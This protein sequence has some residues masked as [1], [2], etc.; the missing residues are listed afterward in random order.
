MKGVLFLL[1]LA[2]APAA[3]DT[4]VAAHTIRAQTLLSP[5]DLAMV[6]RDVPGALTDP[7]DADG[8][9]ARVT[10]YA[11]RPVRAGDL[12]PPAVIDRNQIVPLIYANAILNIVT[13]ARALSRAGVGDRIRAM[14]LDSRATVTGTV[15]ADG[16]ILVTGDRP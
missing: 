5:S 6:P 2:A 9:E 7:A 4:V 16:S 13:E 12:G 8:M 1:A 10:L 14:N 11:G 3:A 15:T